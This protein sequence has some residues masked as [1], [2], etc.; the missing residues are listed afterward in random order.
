MLKC[1]DRNKNSVSRKW[2]AFILTLSM[3]HGTT[4]QGAMCCNTKIHIS[5]DSSFVTTV[6]LSS[7][8]ILH[9]ISRQ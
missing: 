7:L 8:L 9:H 5:G 2:E 3:A 1:R 6:Y 4:A